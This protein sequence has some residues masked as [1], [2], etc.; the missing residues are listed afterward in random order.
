MRAELSARGYRWHETGKER[1]CKGLVVAGAMRDKL[2]LLGAV[3][4]E[5]LIS[6]IEPGNRLQT[7]DWDRVVDVS[8][9]GIM[10]VVVIATTTGTYFADGYGSH[11]CNFEPEPAQQA[12][13]ITTPE[14]GITFSAPVFVQ[15]RKAEGW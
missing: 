11:N 5:R 13:W 3:G 4:A 6:K 2:A 12:L 1:T 14:R 9:G 8:D 15:D 7:S 10:D